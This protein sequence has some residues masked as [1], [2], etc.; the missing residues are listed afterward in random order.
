[1]AE[2]STIASLR[3]RLRGQS[4]W[5]HAWIDPSHGLVL[6]DYPTPA[7]R[8]DFAA[9]R[10]EPLATASEPAER[11]VVDLTHKARRFVA[12]YEL[13][14]DEAVYRFGSATH[15]L[16][17]GLE[18]I[19]A[20]Y[21]GALEQL[22]KVKKRTKRPVAH[23]PEDLYDSPHPAAHATRLSNGFFVATNN[24]ASESLAVVRRAVLLAGIPGNPRDLVRRA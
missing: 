23:R 17:E 21:T 15:L 19:E 4:Q 6:G 10:F 18:L 14:L 12:V 7:V 24:K 11:R 1:M 22:A 16:T 3:S 13:A 9:E 5:A 20:R 8:Y 2:V